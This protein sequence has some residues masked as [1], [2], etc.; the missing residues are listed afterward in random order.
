MKK[1]ID[2]VDEVSKVKGFTK[3][4]EIAKFLGITPASMSNIR[5]GHGVR[6]G[7][8]DKIA[9]TLKAPKED[10]YLASRVAQENDPVAKK[11]WEKIAKKYESVAA[12]IL[13]VTALSPFIAGIQCIL[14]QIAHSKNS[15]TLRVQMN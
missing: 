8:A 3:D 15:T 1:F 4:K 5:S 10:I 6:Q 11:V 14:C 12:S 7:T 2:Y 9:E 13:A